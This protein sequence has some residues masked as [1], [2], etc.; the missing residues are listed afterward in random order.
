MTLSPYL[1]GLRAKVGNDLLLLPAVAVVV[2][3]PN[4][5]LLLV[6]DQET[7]EW[8]L[9]AGAIEPSESPED[10]A[11]RELREEAGIECPSLRLVAGLG[12]ERF[13]HVYENGDEVEYS[14]FVYSGVVAE[15]S[16][17]EPR[18]RAEV[19][20]A[21]FFSR[22]VA[23]ALSLPYPDDVLWAGSV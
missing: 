10:A 12:G 14:L 18:D 4:G 9:P 17:P 2:K 1:A 3:D 22:D 13:R 5:R 15:E 21:R 8:G 7:R 16:I 11:Q 19:A 20:E 6:L 23:P